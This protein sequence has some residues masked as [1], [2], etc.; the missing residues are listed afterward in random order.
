[1]KL[2]QQFVFDSRSAICWSADAGYYVAGAANC[3]IPCP[4]GQFTPNM[5]STNCIYV[6]AGKYAAA[7][8]TDDDG[9]GVTKAATAGRMSVGALLCCIWCYGM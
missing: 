1:M 8:N 6:Q 7:V 4:L 9:I 2:V 3:A 5:S